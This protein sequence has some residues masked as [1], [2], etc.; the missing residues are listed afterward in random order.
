MAKKRTTGKK[1]TN[2]YR[3]TRSFLQIIYPESA[4]QDFWDRL[5]SDV[6]SGYLHGVILSP[7]HDSDW[8]DTEEANKSWTRMQAIYAQE[9]ADMETEKDNR[10]EMLY[11]TFNVINLNTESAEY[12]QYE[13]IKQQIEAEFANAKSQKF[14]DISAKK[15]EKGDAKE[16]HWH[17]DAEFRSPTTL[18]HASEYLQNITRG[19]FAI[20]REKSLK[21]EV[22]YMAHLD[23]NPKKKAQYDPS[24]ILVYGD[25]NID[26]FLTED[27]E[28]MSSLVAWRELKEL[29]DCEC[30]TD[31][32]TFENLMVK[33]DLELQ[34]IVQKNVNLR[35]RAYRYI[36][37]KCA[38]A[39]M[40]NRQKR[41]KESVHTSAYE[42]AY[43][44]M[45]HAGC[46]IDA[47]RVEAEKHANNMLKLIEA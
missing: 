20:V 8:Y 7:L 30:V 34:L 47:S 24:Q 43:Q 1:Y 11:N 19:T 45:A 25:I 42:N 3:K 5:K 37:A 46:T 21:A 44:R 39:S 23:E 18:K 26:R 40:I 12:K 29:I 6:D 22:R 28:T 41:I 36:D 15:H 2:P 38:E 16:Q 13:Q 32:V 31:I 27:E 35:S 4:P 33:Q 10:L 17:L 9:I 14:A